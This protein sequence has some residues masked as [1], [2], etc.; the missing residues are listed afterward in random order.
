MQD[1]DGVRIVRVNHFNGLQSVHQYIRQYYGGEY[2]N[3]W[4]SQGIKIESMFELKSVEK[5]DAFRV[6]QLKS[7]IATRS[8]CTQQSCFDL[9]QCETADNRLRV[10]IYP[11]H[12]IVN[13]TDDRLLTGEFSREYFQVLQSIRN[14]PFYTSDIGQACAFVVPIDT[15]NELQYEKF[16]LDIV[17]SLLTEYAY[18]AKYN[19]SNHLFF[20]FIAG[21]NW[22]VNLQLGNAMLLSAGLSTFHH[23][24][25]FD[26]SLPV[27]SPLAEPFTSGRQHFASH[28]NA[29]MHERRSIEVLLVH[30]NYLPDAIRP[31]FNSKDNSVIMQYSSCNTSN[32]KLY[33]N[34]AN[35]FDKQSYEQLLSSASFCLIFDSVRSVA[36]KTMLT[37]ALMFG[38]IPILTD[39]WT[40]VMPFES[41]IVWSQ[42]S[43]RVPNAHL[44]KL[45]KI[46][47]SLPTDRRYSMRR[48][49][50]VT[51]SKYLSTIDRIVQTGL[52]VL[53]ERL[54]PPTVVSKGKWN[55]LDLEFDPIACYRLT[56]PFEQNRCFERNAFDNQ[57]DAIDPTLPEPVDLR[58]GFTAVILTYDRLDSLLQVIAQVMQAPSL[59]KI[60]VIWNH[61]QNRPPTRHDLLQLISTKTHQT[62]RVP[63]DVIVTIEN[64]LSNRFYPFKEIQTDCVLSIDDDITMLNG[65]ELEFGFQIWREFPDRIVGYPSRVHKFDNTTYR[66]KYDSEW[67]NEMSMVLTGAAFYHKV[68]H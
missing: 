40:L 18:F 67:L 65:D 56:D 2:A 37:E 26:V 17:S 58:H 6:H 31:L 47:N 55:D 29:M 64:R 59:I 63:I 8:D 52:I 5:S 66:W 61:Q 3:R 44:S 39:Q 27:Y 9:Y 22:R 45:D 54:F 32:A 10:Y 46:L 28:I 1:R 62:L 33:C 49:G 21:R 68:S 48:D 35:P 34:D 23:R 12:R 60:V 36:T 30:N 4:S 13:H 42:I 50:L 20:N 51:W 25:E 19:G 38:C 43:L 7:P 15:L 41:K 11:I 24:Y 16:G 14:S 53:N 57:W